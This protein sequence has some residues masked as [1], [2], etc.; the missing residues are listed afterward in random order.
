MNYYTNIEVTGYL[1][2]CMSVTT[3]LAWFSFTVKVPIGPKKVHNYFGEGMLS[4]EIVNRKK[5]LFPFPKCFIF[6]EF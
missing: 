2:V 4:K 3:K 5:K 6:L 1:W